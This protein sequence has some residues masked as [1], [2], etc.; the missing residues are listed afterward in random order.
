MVLVRLSKHERNILGE[1]LKNI[2]LVMI[3]RVVWKILEGKRKI[4]CSW[5]TDQSSSKKNGNIFDSQILS[6]LSKLATFLC[7]LSQSWFPGRHTLPD[8]PTLLI[9][10]SQS[11]WLFFPCLHQHL[12]LECSGAQSLFLFWIYPNSLLI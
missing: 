6:H 9:P 2:N 7:V 3:W 4:K 5:D 1:V 8:S 10:S 11:P 12:T